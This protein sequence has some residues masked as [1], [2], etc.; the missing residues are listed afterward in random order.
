MLKHDI[1]VQIKNIERGDK[2]IIV[3]DSV[4]NLASLKEVT[5]A[6]DGKNSADMTRAKQLKSLFRIITPHLTLKDIP[7]IA[8]SH[9]YQTLEMFSK[10]V[11]SGGTGQ[12]YSADNTYIIGR[13]Q[14]K[15][16][17]EV[18]GYNFIINVEKSRHVKEKSKIPIQVLHKGG[19]SRY[20]GLLDMALE[21]GLVVKPSN[22]WYSRV[23]SE[24]GEIEE[25]RFRQKETNS[26][27]FWQPLLDSE[28]FHNWIENTYKVSTADL[29]A[30]EDIDEAIENS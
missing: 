12:Y 18:S 20:S 9:T 1:S 23:D 5:D 16:G 19:L 21:A 11:V 8:I 28:E 7:V 24:T 29:I 22:G 17:K 13:Q 15:D 27:E 2:A 14:E 25:K 26:K 10:S 6:E 30:D 4:G 3:I